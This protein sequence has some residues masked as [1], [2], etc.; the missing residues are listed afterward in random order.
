[1]LTGVRVVLVGTQVAG[2]LG[3][4]AR[5]MSNF[6]VDDLTLVRPVASIDDRE[7]KRRSARGEYVLDKAHVVDS[8]EAAIADCRFAVAT[9][10][11]IGGFFRPADDLDQVFD[12]AFPSRPET[13]NPTVERA[14]AKIALVFGPEP[15]GLTSAETAQCRFMV[16][17]PTAE[18]NP[19]L[20]LSHAVAI[21]LYEAYRRVHPV[22][23]DSRGAVDRP[24]EKN[25]ARTKSADTQVRLADH[26]LRSRA[27]DRL[28]SAFKRIGYLRPPRESALMY[29][30]KR[31]LDRSEITE[32]EA[33]ML[34]GLAR[35]IDYFADHQGSIRDFDGEWAERN[36]RLERESPGRG[37]DLDRRSTSP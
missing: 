10:S 29:A 31:M 15:S 21:L 12:L 4:T 8:L 5:A 30:I 1:M 18:T 27:Y 19:S 22:F 17:I 36:S 2:N 9:S 14:D 34:I 16:A 6:G 20:N 26:Q 13:T 28:A 7:A 23:A 33:K 25:E 3:A 35:Q 11:Q 37:D 24:T 32:R